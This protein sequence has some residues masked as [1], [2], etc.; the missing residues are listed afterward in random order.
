MFKETNHGSSQEAWEY[1]NETLAR[2]GYKMSL[3]G[4]AYISGGLLISYDHILH[5][6]RQW[7][8]PNFDFGKYFN[9]R[10]HKWSKLIT[11]YVDLNMLDITKSEILERER[12]RDL[13]YNITYLFS[14]SHETGKGC[15]ISIVFSRRH[16]RDNPVMTVSLRSSEVTKR[17]IFD[18]LLCQR[19][20]EYI[21]GVDHMPSLTLIC[22]NMYI[23]G[24]SYPMYGIR[25]PLK[26]FLKKGDNPYSDRLLD[27]ESKYL[28]VNAN[29]VKYK[30]MKR[31]V[32]QVQRDKDIGDFAKS[33]PLL[34]KDL[35]IF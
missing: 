33:K 20:G 9:Y 24:N 29:T 19:I 7:V 5:I 32:V 18:F 34:A 3:N 28:G 35:N 6:N 13:N 16:D 14:N 25:K 12:K 4:T 10:I 15:L 22:R 11:N 21:Y 1:I 23:D 27:I 26:A 31:A 30:V 2:T 8:D 17:L